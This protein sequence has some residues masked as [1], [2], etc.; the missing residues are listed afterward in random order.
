[1]T[2]DFWPDCGHHLLQADERGWLQPTPAYLAA[3]M[4]RPELALVGESCRAEIALHEALRRDPLRP[5]PARELAAL[6][7]ADARENYGHFLGLRDALLQAGTLQGWLLQ[8]WRQRAI[9]VP[10]LFIDLIVQAVVRGLL[11][12]ENA[13]EARAGELLFRTQR[14]STHEGRR[15]AG[16]R[17]TLDLQR[18]TRGFGDLGRLL[19][20]AALPVRAQQMQVLQADTAAAYWAEASRPGGRHTFL[21]DL[22]HEVRQELGHGMSFQLTLAHSGLKALATV[23]ERWVRQLLGVSVHITPLQKVDDAGW[24]WHLGL[25]AAPAQ[26]V[27][28]G[29]RRCRRDAPRCRRQAG[30]SG[31]DGNDRAS[32]AA[33]APEPAVESAT[34]GLRLALTLIKSSGLRPCRWHDKHCYTGSGQERVPN[35]TGAGAA[36]GAEGGQ[37]ATSNAQAKGLTRSPHWRE[38][39]RHTRAA[40]RR[41]KACQPPRAM[42]QC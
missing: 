11:D 37:G 23:L 22:T 20:Q 38:A 42:G 25:D 6:Q 10:P 8:L 7:D 9:R 30:L 15:L 35:P 16:D 21:L 5:V 41:G 32:P 27:P 33:E 29:L 19:A 39:T 2:I 26:P 40:H 1:V 31:P 4:V 36:E 34:G 12:G 3:W 14:I 24:R 18:D 13:F 28:A 17:E